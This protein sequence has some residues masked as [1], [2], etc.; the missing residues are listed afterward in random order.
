[1]PFTVLFVCTG[2]ICRSPLGERLFT[3][4]ATDADVRAVSAG[5]SALVGY[6]IDGPSA[7]VL[8]E[9][10]G[11]PDGHTA[12]RISRT[13]VD[14]A[15][16]I[17]TAETSHRS[18][19]LRAEPAAF[20]RTFTMREFARLG[21]AAPAAGAR[22]L[23]GLRERVFEIAALRGQVA[24]AEPGG[25]DVG[26]PYGGSLEIARIAGHQI[27]TAVDAAIDALGL[28]SPAGRRPDGR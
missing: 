27:A 8:R 18:T 22:D 5:T 13:L 23:A 1:V 20:R 7:L 6:G 15:D 10:G 3:A 19:V 2:N 12:Q 26:D 11:D 24:A 16:L 28:V 17:L 4:R 9:L 14:S 25:D 21:A